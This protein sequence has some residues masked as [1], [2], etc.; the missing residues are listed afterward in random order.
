MQTPHPDNPMP[1][2][3]YFIVAFMLGTAVSG[4]AVNFLHEVSMSWPVA[5]R[6]AVA[7]SPM[8]FGAAY[9]ARAFTFGRAEKLTL[10]QALRRGIPFMSSGTAPAGRNP[11]ERSDSHE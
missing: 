10:R 1:Y 7:L 9:G 5:A 6:L 8:V 3:A 11:S 2:G 4:L